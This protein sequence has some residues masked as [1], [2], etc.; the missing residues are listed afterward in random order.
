MDGINF[1]SPPEVPELLIEHKVNLH[2][3]SYLRKRILQNSCWEFVSI[4]W[5]GKD[6][7]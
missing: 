3:L 1:G 6:V 4:I 5:K 2:K 7:V